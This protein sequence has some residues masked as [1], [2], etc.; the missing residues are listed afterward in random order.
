M[1]LDDKAE[2]TCMQD[3]SLLNDTN[4]CAWVTVPASSPALRAP[5]SGLRDLTPA[6]SP[7]P[8]AVVP[9]KHSIAATEHGREGGEMSEFPL[10]GGH[11]I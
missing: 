7:K 1:D 10:D 9:F 2:R 6:P 3:R 4:D 8:D 11:L 5:A